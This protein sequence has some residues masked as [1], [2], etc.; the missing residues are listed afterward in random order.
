M[1]LH[2]RSV[3]SEPDA[4]SVA[5]VSSALSVALEDCQINFGVSLRPRYAKYAGLGAGG[6]QTGM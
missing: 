1:L 5:F 3:S 6:S 2:S 4:I